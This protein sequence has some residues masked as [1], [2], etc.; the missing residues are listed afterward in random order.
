MEPDTHI[1][2]HD[3]KSENQEEDSKAGAPPAA[4]ATPPGDPI[5]PGDPPLTNDPEWTLRADEDLCAA[6]D[7]GSSMLLS[8]IHSQGSDGSD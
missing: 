1:K 7:D 3:D 4:S 6:D 2:K 8:S 5:P